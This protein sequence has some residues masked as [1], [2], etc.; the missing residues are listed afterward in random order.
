MPNLQENH[1]RRDAGMDSSL[2]KTIRLRQKGQLTLP[3]DIL[4]HL[5]LSPDTKLKITVMDGRIV[6]IP[7]IEI[8]KD[9]A[10]YWGETWQKD[11]REAQ[12]DIEQGMTSGAMDIDGA[13]A[14][15]KSDD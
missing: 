13:L 7:M 3:A 6:L 2:S 5:D 10:W 15:L 4:E 9:Q 14:W 8:A 12:Q 1:E 11:E